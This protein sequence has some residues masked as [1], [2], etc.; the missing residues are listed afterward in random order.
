MSHPKVIRFDRQAGAALPA[1]P[2]IPAAQLESGT[3]R[4]S[5]ITYFERPEIGLSAGIWECTAF[6]GKMEPYPVDEFM[7]VLEG[8]VTIAEPGGKQTTIRAG[9]SFVLPRGLKC[10]WRQTGKMRKF[11]VIYE[12]PAGAPTAPAA[13]PQ[14]IKPDH[15]LVP[16]ES[17]PS[18]AAETLIGPVPSQR[19]HSYYTDPSG[20]FTVGIWDTSYYHRKVVPFPRYE[21][22]CFLDGAVSMTDAAGSSETFNAG[23]SVF[24]PLGAP[25]DFKVIGAYLRKIY[26]IFMPQA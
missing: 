18:P 17:S 7:L 2:D 1:W 11:F 3:P 5:G 9:E 19:S 8:E 24:V 6:I 12:A 21:L 22:M 13:G 10:Q 25:A 4:Q 26:V 16:Q 14:V 20:Q 23:D 15:R